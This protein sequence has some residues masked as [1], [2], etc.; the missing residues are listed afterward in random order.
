MPI[1]PSQVPVIGNRTK[2]IKTK[3]LETVENVEI[4]SFTYFILFF[5]PSIFMREKKRKRKKICFEF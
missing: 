2:N 3:I 5:V 1:S 4:F